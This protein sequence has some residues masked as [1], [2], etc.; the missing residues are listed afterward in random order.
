[1]LIQC[2]PAGF[3]KFMAEFAVELPSADSPAPPPS[4]AEIE[5]LLSIA[6]R[7]GI[8]MLPPPQ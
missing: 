8:V 1:M 5:K 2:V 4:P 3:D 6:P 7:Y